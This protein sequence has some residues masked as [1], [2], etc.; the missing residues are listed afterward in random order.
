MENSAVYVNKIAAAHPPYECHRQVVQYLN[1]LLPPDS[2]MTQRLA[3]VVAKLGI[4]KRYS[5]FENTFDEHEDRQA[6]FYS[7]GFFP[8]TGERMKAYA[9]KA[10]PLASLAIEPLLCDEDRSTITHVIVTSC[11]GFYAP[12]ID[13]DI[14]KRFGL[15]RDVERTLIGFMG[16]YAAI[17]ALKQAFHIVRS[18]PSAKVLIVNVEICSLHFRE[19]APLDQQLSF[20]LFADGAAASLVS[21]RAQGLRLDSFH[22]T[23][24]PQTHEL[25]G[26][27]IGDQGFYMHLDEKIPAA[28]QIGLRNC[29]AEI[30]G[31]T[32]INQMASWAIH[33]GGRG[34]LDAIQNELQLAENALRFSRA[35]LRENGNLSS[36]TIMFVLQAILQDPI[37]RGR[38]CGMAFGPGLTL[39]S[40]LYSI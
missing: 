25:M 15:R 18:Q 4:E 26:W 31:N 30:L 12:G 34:I 32:S 39:E 16:C 19:G 38:G 33:P 9:E 23:L 11:T 2:D 24:L 40:F 6:A 8:T 36:A 21:A 13:I 1:G 28:I 35:V 17:P 10:L 37:S 7:T 14:I 3:R 22:S 20:L 29:G 5:V 27:T